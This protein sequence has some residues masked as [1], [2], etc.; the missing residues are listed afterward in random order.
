LPPT[1]FFGRNDD[2]S[3]S[4]PQHEQD[5]ESIL[6]EAQASGLPTRE[7]R[8]HYRSRHESLIAFSNW[9]YYG[10]NLITFP[11]PVTQD[12][13][14]SFAFV[15]TGVYGRG[16]SRANP[17]EAR[18][19]VADIH[20]RLKVWLQM[21][22]A[23]R[24]T[25]GVITFN[26]PQQKLILDLLDKLR[27]DNPACEWF[28]SEDRVEPIIVK[29]LENIQ[30]DERDVILFSIT[31]CRD[32]AGKLPMNFGAIN[33][34]GGERRLNVAVTRARRELKVFS[35]IRADDIDVNRSKAVGVA[36]LKAFLD[37]AVR[38]VIALPAQDTGSQGG[39]ESPFEEAVAAK[40][41]LHGWRVV[42][43]VGVSGFRVDLGICHPDHAG[44]YLAGVEC[45]GAT[46]HR[47]ATA[48]D[49][50][51][52][53]EQILRGLGWTIF[54]VW[55]T[56][57]WFSA[58]EAIE[59]L[60]ANLEKALAD[61]RSARAAEDE[62]TKQGTATEIGEGNAA[63]AVE[64]A[65]DANASGDLHDDIEITPTEP[66]VVASPL[67]ASPL[68]A[69]PMARAMANS[70]QRTYSATDLSPF[71]AN[72]ELFFEFSY[73][74]TLQAMVDAI[75]AHEAPLREDVLAQRIARA[76]GWLRTGAR[77]RDQIAR[78]L[79]RLER[80]QETPGVFVWQP[81]TVSPRFPFRQPQSE[82]HRRP[83]SDICLPELVDFIL[84]HRAALDE[85]DPPLVYARLLQLERLAASSRERLEEAITNAL[86]L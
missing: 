3:D 42:P 81:G 13:A 78:H 52:L 58:Q 79:R 77:I 56:D 9:H 17:E 8:W 25:L 20:V 84:S 35:G 55:S 69:A 29:N 28:F 46:Y 61:S 59:L 74:S 76:H 36:H 15:P 67:L 65:D 34:S 75:I 12:Q 33:N 2:D 41:E 22:E 86:L 44:I 27:S 21:P 26:L 5:L 64:A 14:V 82:E 32:A 10:N 19:I 4:V 6:D 50:D 73:R 24:P 62:R 1:N 71:K 85:A 83:L 68:A 23:D 43:Q 31:Y 51:K 30:G 37:Y 49:R 16:S 63:D 72:P 70:A 18:A 40:L 53:R 11:S 57:W 38:G 45:D 47:S 80:T 7:L 66:F 54:H 39:F 60:H 48:R